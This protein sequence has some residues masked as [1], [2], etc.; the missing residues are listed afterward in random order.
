MY[1]NSSRRKFLRILDPKNTHAGHQA[2]EGVVPLIIGAVVLLTMCVFFANQSVKYSYEM[3]DLT[4]TRDRLKSQKSIMEVKLQGMM[5]DEQVAE[6]AK[7]RYGFK[8]AERKEVIVA[9]AY[10]ASLFDRI[11]RIFGGGTS[12]R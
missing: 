10:N 9:D 11:G 2:P 5:S 1:E 4:K 12:D 6:V 3:S 8:E 7:K